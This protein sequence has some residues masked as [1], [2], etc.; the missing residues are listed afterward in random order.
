MGQWDKN[1]YRRIFNCS[2]ASIITKIAKQR[3]LME[4]CTITAV[5]EPPL[6]SSTKY[7]AESK[8]ILFTYSTSYLTAVDNFWNHWVKIQR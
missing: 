4:E 1:A 5:Q 2:Q 3:S 8:A 7:L 6:C